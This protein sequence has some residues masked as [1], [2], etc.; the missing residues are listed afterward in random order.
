[1]LGV[2][3]PD[4]FSQSGPPSAISKGGWCGKRLN[5]SISFQSEPKSSHPQISSRFLTVQIPTRR[6]H[7]MEIGERLL[8]GDLSRLS[9][10]AV[11]LATLSYECMFV[12]IIGLR[13]CESNSLLRGNVQAPQDQRTF[14]PFLPRPRA[15]P[16]PCMRTRT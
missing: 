16:S 15:R 5:V 6:W 1:M 10:G 9:T 4:Y 8:L 11:F 7:E 13:K 14:K 3:L 12:S 2:T